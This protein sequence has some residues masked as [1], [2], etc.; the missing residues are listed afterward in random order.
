MHC[1]E[2]WTVCLVKQVDV[3]DDSSEGLP[4]SLVKHGLVDGRKAIFFLLA[5]LVR[6]SVRF[7]GLRK[8]MFVLSVV[9]WQEQKTDV[10]NWSLSPISEL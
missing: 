4:V 8:P 3:L 5:H 7:G 10:V 2:G 6:L 1:D 9:I